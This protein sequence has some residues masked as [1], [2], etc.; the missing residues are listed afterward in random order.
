MINYPENRIIITQQRLHKSY[1]RAF[2]HSAGFHYIKKSRK[3]EFI[4][5][6]QTLKQL[7]RALYL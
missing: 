5:N 4:M 7:G 6:I 2:G 3:E 1:N